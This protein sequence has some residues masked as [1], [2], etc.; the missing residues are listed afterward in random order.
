MNNDRKEKRVFPCGCTV[1]W[2][3]DKIM[4]TD[5]TAHCDGAAAIEVKAVGKTTVTV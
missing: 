3:L 2:R 1:E 4:F 5:C